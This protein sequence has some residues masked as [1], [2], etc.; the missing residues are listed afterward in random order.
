MVFVR[1]TTQLCMDNKTSFF[2]NHIINLNNVFYRHYYTVKSN[3]RCFHKIQADVSLTF[4]QVQQDVL[5]RPLVVECGGKSGYNN[6]HH[7]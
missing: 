7:H 2:R 5:Q 6:L 3:T 1:Y 4:E